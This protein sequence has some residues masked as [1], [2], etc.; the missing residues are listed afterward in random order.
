[1]ESAAV[2]EIASDESRKQADQKNCGEERMAKEKFGDAR[3]GNG[4]G[5]WIRAKGEVI[6]AEGFDDE[7]GEDHGVGVINVEHE[8]GD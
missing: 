2:N 3:R 7:D 8:S 4:W 5:G 6:L 1:L